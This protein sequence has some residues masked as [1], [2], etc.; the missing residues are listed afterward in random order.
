[1]PNI[2]AM[3]FLVIDFA[4]YEAYNTVDYALLMALIEK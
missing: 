3:E 4:P 2:E 1:M